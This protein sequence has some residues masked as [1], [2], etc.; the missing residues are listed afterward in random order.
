MRFL[1][2][3]NGSLAVEDR[4][5]RRPLPCAH[6]G[7]S[8]PRQEVAPLNK[9]Q[10]A[11]KCSFEL[12]TLILYRV[13]QVFAALVLADEQVH[14]LALLNKLDEVRVTVS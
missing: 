4:R 7:A 11:P 2:E 10:N 13:A 9:E 14:L 5:V 8:A 12:L 1:T 6:K 3:Q